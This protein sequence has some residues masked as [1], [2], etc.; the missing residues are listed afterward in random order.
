MEY[1]SGITALLMSAL[2]GLTVA[3][4][5]Q[6]AV[7][8]IPNIL[9]IYSDDLG[10]GDLS[11]YGAQAVKTP[12]IDALAAQGR[13]FTQAYATAA[14]CTPSRYSLLTGQYAWRKPGTQVLP[15]DA[16]SII[17]SGRQTLP[18]M[19]KRAGYVTGIVGKWHLGLGDGKNPIDWNKT[20]SH[21][22]NQVGFDS[23]FIIPATNDR[24][25]CVYLENGK[26]VNLDPTDPIKVSYR[27]KIG[28]DP[29]G[30]SHPELLRLQ[31]THGHNGTIVNGVSR[32]GFM[33]GGHAAR[34][35]D[36]EMA[37]GFVTRCSDFMTRS[38]QSDSPFF[39]MFSAVDI[40]VPRLPH[41]RF[42]G[43]SALGTR[44]DVIHQLD[45][46]VGQLMARLGQLGIAENTIVIFSSDNGPFLDD[47]YAD[48]AILLNQ[49]PEGI[50]HSPTGLLRGHKYSIYEGGCRIPMIVRWS[51]KITNPGM[52]SEAVISQMDLFGSLAALL[53]QPL[54]R[55]VVTDAQDQRAALFG[56]DTKGREWL[57][58]Q[59]SS[60]LAL[61]WKNYKF[62]PQCGEAPFNKG[63]SL[64]DLKSDPAEKKNIAEVHPE[65][66]QQCR[67]ILE[68]CTEGKVYLR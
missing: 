62:V 43:T 41:P 5:T 17:D 67:E 14:T 55:S 34:W 52:K 42:A 16:A 11:C 10:Y 40:H 18:A 64:F 50:S 54:D 6:P 56:C 46:S 25:P 51:E 23:S 32:I 8:K 68:K 27:R 38:A 39:L 7:Q 35:V 61:R 4:E 12:K 37:D 57:V 2:P 58:E 59:G 65:K 44:G 24:V 53:N 45:W 26:C 19:L 33:S 49:N 66:V 36:E 28:K 3:L 20:V 1:L 15:G 21:G 60:G 63:F 30:L 48:S 13:L 22:P 31:T 29:T 47:G 9:L